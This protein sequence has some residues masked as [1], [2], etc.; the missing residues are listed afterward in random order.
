MRIVTIG[1]R[2]W[3]DVAVKT[4]QH[5]NEL[6]VTGIS[7]FS[8]TLPKLS[9]VLNKSALK[10]S[11]EYRLKMF[12]FEINNMV[13]GQLKKA[14]CDIV[15][16]DFIDCCKEIWECTLKDGCIVRCTYGEVFK[17]NISIVKSKIEESYQTTIISE[18]VINPL[19]WSDEKLDEEIHKA[20]LLMKDICEGRKLVLLCTQ[21]PFHY[22]NGELIINGGDYNKIAAINAFSNKCAAAFK[23]YS[24]CITVPLN[25][26]VL[27]GEEYED[28]EGR[29]YTKEYYEYLSGCL[30][31]IEK[32]CYVQEQPKLE[33]AY[34]EAVHARVD[35]V[36][37]A[38]MNNL[39]QRVK[40]RK[41]VLISYSEET[42][43]TL[44]D[45]Y[46]L[47]VSLFIHYDDAV[48][49]G[50]LCSRLLELRGK[51]DEY[52]II[53]PFLANSDNLLELLCKI[54]FYEGKGCILS[55]SV[56][57][58]LYNFIGEYDDVYGNH[59]EGGSN[60]ITVT[61][62]GFGSSCIIEHSDNYE[63]KNEFELISQGNLKL[64]R[65]IAATKCYILLMNN[66]GCV[67]GD[68]TSLPDSDRLYLTNSAYLNIGRDCM[69]SSKVVIHVGDGHAIFNNVTGEKINYNMQEPD[70][71]KLRVV[72]GE[73]VWIGYEAVLLG[74][75]NVGNGSII[76]ARSLVNNSFPN[77]CIIAGNAAKL[78]KKDIAWSRTTYARN[79]YE[80]PGTIEEK[81]LQFT[82]EE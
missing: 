17:E 54:G 66:A 29:S 15:C 53:V 1:S 22:T 5:N 19:S 13:V 79:V 73:H 76:G 43:N 31:S 61:F 69:F 30:L 45:L 24:D 74:G 33:K 14:K 50:E 16:I 38:N 80:H 77:N 28:F 62:Y 75:T 56:R 49:D 36:N 42:K 46:N 37:I 59:F 65:D 34:E 72:L 70:N 8:M 18:K 57:K 4:A 2:I 25:R 12:D 71:N 39:S 35:A 23:K 7:L 3:D 10:H 68:D 44:L 6:R 26:Y 40:G 64:G 82:R 58:I 48:K 11:N 27:G 51:N 52:V 41:I 81:F 60:N 20:A 67:I 63:G 47:N 78:I 32:N 21:I 55:E 9:K